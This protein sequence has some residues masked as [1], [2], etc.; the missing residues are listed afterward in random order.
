MHKDVDFLYLHRDKPYSVFIA[1]FEVLSSIA[2]KFQS[3]IAAEFQLV[4]RQSDL[5]L[6][7]IPELCRSESSSNWFVNHLRWLNFCEFCTQFRLLV[8]EYSNV[9][10][11]FGEP[12]ILVCILCGFEGFIIFKESESSSI[13][14][15]KFVDAHTHE[16]LTFDKV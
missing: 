3:Y 12:Q 7:Q 11:P 13:W 9:S 8:Y 4:S 14:S 15:E 1:V 16:S 2:F 6:W 10:S 5:D